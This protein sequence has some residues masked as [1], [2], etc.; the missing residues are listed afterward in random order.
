MTEYDEIARDYSDTKRLPFSRHIE[1]YTLF[2][3]LGDVRGARALDLSCGDGFYARRLKE[4]GAC[5]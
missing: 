1:Q 5:P 2:Q 4:A 3:I